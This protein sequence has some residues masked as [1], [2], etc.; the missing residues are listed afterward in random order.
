MRI[1]M[2]AL[3]VGLLA[4]STSFGVFAQ[5]T[6]ANLSAPQGTVLVSQGDA[7]AAGT[8]GQRLP[9]NTR[10]VTTAGAS[11]TINY[12]KGCVVRL[13]EN[14]R[15]VVQESGD[16]AALIA[17]VQNV[18]AG[19]AGA[20]VAGGA[21]AAAGGAGAFAGSGAIIGATLTAVA[22]GG[23]ALAADRAKTNSSF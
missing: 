9:A 10:V 3:S 5:A 20:T 22:F 19:A 12:D 7:M 4:A 11:A 14:Q 17:A 16:C 1:R 2:T 23:A 15:F 13:T 18:G 21:G 6:V 8:A